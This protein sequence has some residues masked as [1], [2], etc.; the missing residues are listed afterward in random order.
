MN[1]LVGWPIF[2]G[3]LLLVSGNVNSGVFPTSV[4]VDLS[5][6]KKHQI[7]KLRNHFWAGSKRQNA[8]YKLDVRS[9]GKQ[10]CT[11]LK[12]NIGTCKWW[13]SRGISSSSVYFLVTCLTFFVIRDRPIE[14]TIRRFTTKTHEMG[15]R[16][17]RCLNIVQWDFKEEII[18][19]NWCQM[20]R[21]WMLDGEWEVVNFGRVRLINGSQS[22]QCAWLLLRWLLQ[23]CRKL[24]KMIQFD[25]H[26]SSGL[27]PQTS[28]FMYMYKGMYR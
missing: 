2:K 20:G 26:V 4:L 18:P 15:P 10:R 25:F 21:D 3:L 16:V 9:N 24:V 7:Q 8:T 5:R 12:S 11:H 23:T 28:K 17:V 27:K 1:F 6:E 19:W 22:Y 13:C 14:D